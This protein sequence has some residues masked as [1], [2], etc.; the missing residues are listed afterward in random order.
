MM[1]ARRARY[2]EKLLTFLV[3]VKCVTLTSLALFPGSEKHLVDFSDYSIDFSL[4]QHTI[5]T[6]IFAF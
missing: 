6:Y 2:M 5:P 3:W 1:G 4:T